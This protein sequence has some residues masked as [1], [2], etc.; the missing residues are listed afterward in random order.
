MGHNRPKV[1]DNLI[2]QIQQMIADN[3]DWNRTRLSKELCVL[4]DWQSPAGQIKHV[5]C[6]DLLRAL[7]KRG[8]ISLPAARWTP[9]AP[10]KGAD[11]IRYIEHDTDPINKELRDLMPLRIEIVY[12]K[13]DTDLFKSYIHLYHYLGYGRSAGENIKYFVYSNTGA[14]VACLMFGAAAWSCRARDEYIGWDSRQRHE[15]LTFIANNCRT[16]IFP[17]VHVPCLASHTLG[18]VSR[19]ISEDW[20]RKYGHPLYLLE[21]CIERDRFQGICFKAANWR[22]AGATTGLGRNSKTGERTL[23]IKDFLLYP[24]HGDFR[25]KLC[26]VSGWERRGMRHG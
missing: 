14:I 7:D 8:S 17:W 11:K 23:P 6:R 15:G 16:L 3:P 20:K 4:W 19:R 18:A 26:N 12:S 2:N 13:R 9:R 5:S 22:N 25:K 24:L 10:G 1:T 21:T